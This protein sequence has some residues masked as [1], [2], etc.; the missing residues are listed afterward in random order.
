MVREWRNLKMLKRGG[1]GH[2]LSG[3]EGTK[4]GELALTCP[5]C[6][7][8]NINLPQGW[9]NT[10]QYK[11]Y[12]LLYVRPFNPSNVQLFSASSTVFLLP[13]MQASVYEID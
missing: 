1:R 12:G 5:A 11:A 9:E 2:E 8:P 6:P 7:Q 4:S 13:L 3:V 10:A